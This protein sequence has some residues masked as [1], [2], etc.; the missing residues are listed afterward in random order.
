MFLWSPCVAGVFGID[1]E[2]FECLSKSH[3]RFISHFLDLYGFPMT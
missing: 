3:V 2:D 1:W